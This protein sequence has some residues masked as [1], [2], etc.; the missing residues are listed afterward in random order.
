M[1]SNGRPGKP[2]SHLAHG[3]MDL[4]TGS[5]PKSLLFFSL[6]M[7][8]GSILQ[9]AYSL[10]N[11]FWVGKYLGTA[12]LA[13]VTVS[14]PAIFVLVALGAGLTI[15]TNILIAQYV[16]A[17]E[18]EKLKDV[19]Q[20]SIIV[21]I[22]LSI[23]FLATGLSFSAEILKLMNT[24][25]DVV[26]PALNYINIYFWTLPFG[27]GIFLIGA[28][29][30][31]I[32]DSKTPLYFQAGA[33]VLNAILDPLLIFG[34]AGFPRL[35]LNGTAYASIIVQAL[36]VAGLII[37]IP[38]KRPLVS[39]DLTRLRISRHTAWLLIRI[40]FPAM[41]QQSVVSVSLFFIVRFVSA[42]GANADA[43]F[44]AALRIDQVA[45]LPALTIGM[46]VSTLSGQNIGAMKLDRVRS[47]F[48][49]GLL[50]SGGISLVITILAM[51]IP[52]VFLRAFLRDT[53][54]NLWGVRVPLAW[55]L[56]QYMHGVRGVW[57]AMTV[58]VGTGMILSLAYNATG[59]WKVP[60]IRKKP[61]IGK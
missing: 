45:F 10:V 23:I 8:A 11:A 52:Q 14:F 48:W 3:G 1:I 50:E 43:A 20:T 29:L 53:I 16:G 55:L 37:Y 34:V 33:V 25:E 39:P 51:S 19:V 42:F 22:L 12:A 47:V 18:W 36:A 26:A 28:M 17:R 24:P 56:P 35:G 59:R 60:V 46:A 21:V 41:V 61:G 44:G 38:Y 7:L 49:W 4:T 27:F 54:L 57:I 31:G 30:R 15:A 40:G 2:D 32:G 13:A 58:S 9:T 6:P 5:I